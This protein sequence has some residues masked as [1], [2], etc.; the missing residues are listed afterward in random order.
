M[1]VLAFRHAREEDLGNIRP[2][3]E[4]QG[5]EVIDVDL[6]AGASLPDTSSAAGLI[7]MGGAMCA[8]DGLDFLTRELDLIRAAAGRGQPVFGV[9]LGAQLIAK[10][11][12]GRVYRSAV[13]ETGWS[14][15]ELTQ[16]AMTDPLF[17]PLPRRT[18]VFQLHQDTFDLPEGAVWLA[19]SD[20]CA[21][22]AFR[23]G[24]S[25]Y[26]LQFHPEITPQMGAEWRDVLCLP[27]FAT[28]PGAYRRLRATCETLLCGWKGLL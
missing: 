3:L 14:T 8:N 17:A 28:P 25:I 27:N 1:R 23:A 24:R 15:I 6:Y 4:A 12:G 9:C 10:A 16:A 22:Q 5:V 18:E 2:V 7:F 19:K 26:G 13:Q 21:N 11:L 20:A